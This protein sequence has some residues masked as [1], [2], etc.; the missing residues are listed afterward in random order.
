MKQ[1][2]KWMAF[3]LAAAMAA[4]ACSGC[5][6]NRGDPG[7]RSGGRPGIRRGDPDGS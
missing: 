1:K 6:S 7:P 2:R 5:V 3:V 4:G